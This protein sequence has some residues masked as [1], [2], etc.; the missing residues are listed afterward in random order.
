LQVWGTLTV[1]LE[2]KQRGLTDAVEP[3]LRRLEEAGM[4]ISGSLRDRVLA[5]ADESAAGRGAE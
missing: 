5:L 4:W 2:S 3:H 1:L